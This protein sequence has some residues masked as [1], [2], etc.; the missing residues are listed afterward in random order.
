MIVTEKSFKDEY[1]IGSMDLD[2]DCFY[3][4]GKLAVPYVY[5]MC[6]ARGISL[7][8]K[9]AKSLSEKLHNDWKDFD[10]NK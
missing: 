3:C 9:C 10:R 1:T 7:H 8:G 6:V 5:W 2:D 4:G